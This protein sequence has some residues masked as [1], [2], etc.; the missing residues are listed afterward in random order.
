MSDLFR[1]LPAKYSLLG[2]CLRSREGSGVRDSVRECRLHEKTRDKVS[3]HTSS[4]DVHISDYQCF[5]QLD[6]VGPVDN[7]PYTT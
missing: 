7:R 2:Q 3:D 5:Y 4:V 6:G 1:I